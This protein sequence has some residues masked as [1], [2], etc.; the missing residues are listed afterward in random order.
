MHY[1]VQYT[2]QQPVWSGMSCSLCPAS[3]LRPDVQN[4]STKRADAKP[5]TAKI[6]LA[7]APQRAHGVTAP[8][9][10]QDPGRVAR[11]FGLFILSC[12]LCVCLGQMSRP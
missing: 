1:S 12:V 10:L 7:R 6:A 3:I 2:R 11:R 9:F 5:L 4:M 8:A